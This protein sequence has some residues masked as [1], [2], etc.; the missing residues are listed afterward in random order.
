[1]PVDNIAQ[2]VVVDISL[3]HKA[4]LNLKG[5]AF[6]ILKIELQVIRKK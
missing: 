6:I 4:K 3:L 2:M 1:M 5:G